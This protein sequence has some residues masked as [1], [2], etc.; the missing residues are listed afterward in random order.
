M[1]STMMRYCLFQIANY[2]YWNDDAIASRSVLI[3]RFVKSKS[4]PPT[5]YIKLQQ[6]IST[7]G[8]KGVLGDL[9]AIVDTVHAF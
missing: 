8:R 5:F 2:E 9:E 6:L 1:C 7:W 4:E 3:S